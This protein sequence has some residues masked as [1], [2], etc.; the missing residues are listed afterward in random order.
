LHH[1]I[2]GFQF[3]HFRY[4]GNILNDNFLRKSAMMLTSY[5]EVNC[6]VSDSIRSGKDADG[7]SAK[8]CSL[9]FR[10]GQDL[11][12]LFPFINGA[13]DDALWYERPDHVRFLFEGCRCMLHPVLAVA[14]FFDSR[15]SALV[16]I[17]RL[18]DFLNGLDAGKEEIR[19]N[20][21]RIRHV[22]VLDILKLLPGTNCRDCGFPTCMALAAAV[23]RGR[24][25]ADQCPGLGRPMS[26]NAVYP[27]F[28]GQ[29]NL[30]HSVSLQIDTAGLKRRIRNQ[31]DR[32]RKLEARLETTPGPPNPEPADKQDVNLT[33][34]EIEVL[35][36]IAKGYTNNEIGRLLFISP[37]TVK[38]HMINIFNK[39]TVSDRTQAAV[40]AVRSGLI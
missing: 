24:A 13:V 22:R 16:F 23:A 19:P 40:L 11:A 5:S 27:V 10:P 8:V 12:F 32:I 9:S 28:D 2:G 35:A 38:S 29:G 17:P 3:S 39:L 34:R 26:E 33:G 37:H 7:M 15:A 31:D 6:I 4:D 30:V 14:H 18:M 25:T 20:Y 1:P 21:N 36:L